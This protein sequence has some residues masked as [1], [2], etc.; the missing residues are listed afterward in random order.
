[1]K[2]G[3]A[4]VDV[5]EQCQAYLDEKIASGEFV[6]PAGVSF[7]FA[8]SYENQV[9]SQKTLAIILPIAL[10][11]IFVILYFQF[12][13]VPTTAIVFSGI[14][15]AWAGGFVMVWLYG[16]PW[17]LRFS[18]FGTDMQTLFQ[19]HRNQ[20]KCGDLGWLPGFVRYRIGQRC[21]DCDVP[22]S[23]LRATSNPESG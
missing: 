9:R 22:Q 19:V 3:H 4:E 14:L 5:V 20:S 23:K 11:V 13:S 2:P 10:F 8:G 18:V 1:M 21:C 17:F 7:T 6:L 12:K 15:V 16:Q